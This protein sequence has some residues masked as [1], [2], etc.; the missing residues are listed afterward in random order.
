MLPVWHEPTHNRN[1]IPYAS[2]LTHNALLITPHGGLIMKKTQFCVVT[3]IL[4]LIS[5]IASAQVTFTDVTET[6]GLLGSEIAKSRST[7]WGD[8]DS[9]GDPDLVLM[10]GEIRL[11]RNE[12]N[13][14]FLN[15]TQAVGIPGTRFGSVAGTFA[16]FDN[17][18]D[19]DLLLNTD[20]GD[21]LYRNDGTGAFLD[22]SQAAGIQTRV[23]PSGAYA[24]VFFDYDM[25]GLLDI[26]VTDYDDNPNF[27]YHNEG[28]G[29]FEEVAAQMGADRPE[30]I[31]ASMGIILGDYDD[32][33]DLDLFIAVDG[34]ADVPPGDSV[35]YRNDGNG[36]FV[37]VVRQAG[38][39][40]RANHNG[41]FWDYD[42]DGDLDLLIQGDLD[43][44]NISPMLGSF[45]YRNNGDGTFTDI[46][47]ETG[48]ESFELGT[49]GASFG[50][51]DNDGWL[52]LVIPYEDL[53]TFLYHNNGDGTFTDVGGETGLGGANAGASNFVDYDSDGDLDIFIG[54]GENNTLA[55]RFAADPT[56]YLS[57]GCTNHWLQLRLIGRQSN[58]DSIGARVK[59]T[60]GGLSM[61]Q[62][63][64]GGSGRTISQQDRLPLHFGLGR[65]IQA[66]VVEIRWPSGITQTLTNIPSNQRLT[67]D[68]LDGTMIVIQRASPAVG[69][70]RG[71]TPIQV[72]GEHFLPGSRIFF[73]GVEASDV[74][75][76]SPSLMTAFTPPG[77]RGYVD[78]EV[79]HPDGKRGV[80]RDAFRYTTLRLSNITP[81]SGPVAGGSA[82]QVEGFGIQLGAQVRIGG[83]LLRDVSVTPPVL[84]RGTTPPGVSGTADVSVTNTDGEWDLLY[85]AFTYVPPPEIEEVSPTFAP[86]KG[87][88]DIQISGSGFHQG[89]TVQISGVTAQR[90]HF[91]SP[92]ELNVRTP[93]VSD[94]G[95]Q[96]VVIINPDGQRAILPD[97]VT[98]L[99]PIE[100]KSVE[101]A[102]GGLEGGTRITIVGEP[103]VEIQPQDTRVPARSFPSRFVERVKVFIGDA[104]ATRETVQSDNIITAITPPNTPG[105]K[106]VTVINVDGQE[107]TLRDGFVYNPLPQIARV[108][109]DNGRLAGGTEITVQGSGFLPGARV[110]FST[111]TGTLKAMSS[112]QVVSSTTITAVTT[113]DKSGARDV[114]VRN[115]DKQE[116]ILPEGFTYNPLPTII[117]ITP[118]YGVSSGGTKMIIE[119]NGFLQ[120]A[121]AM[122]GE[123]S[124]TAQWQD[125]TTIEAVAPANPQGAWDVRV[126][127]PDTQEAV[128]REGFISV[129]E[130]AYNYPNPF[131]ASEG[132]TFRY[133][134]DKPVE[135]VAVRIF[136]MA[137]VPIDFVQQI[138][139]NEVKWHNSEVH[140]GLYIYLMEVQLEDRNVRQFRNMLEVYQ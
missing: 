88:R 36:V 127:N 109:P 60:A 75:I 100:I 135:S 37:D 76:A 89:L 125:E 65:N 84:T 86:L 107:D 136:N 101:P 9:D 58:R 120:G 77:Q 97:A 38:I 95:P 35:F 133:V 61:L 54:A 128:K 34:W 69:E 1:R 48:I 31:G 117:S 39:L 118:S 56:L 27:L 28:N 50:D 111:D 87:G 114:V 29:H 4:F 15:V 134:T 71:G 18:G 41:F 32:D 102:S 138:E 68:E 53:R 63:I 21:S 3:F 10:N 104:E 130:L 59:V 67:I 44:I 132:T 119:G 112:S 2:L 129:G 106:D 43:P 42:N 92:E 110:L 47:Q 124:A 20:R 26:Y 113:A 139:S 45:L 91:L 23:S 33:V 90:V 80:L 57:D 17:D 98:I 64:A 11:Y 121:R 115:P 108:T 122:I 14:T 99:A 73:G 126:I 70:P 52:D 5:A 93:E 105:P 103:T 74:Y 25:D 123:R 62:E 83:E 22:V 55:A 49:W 40:H 24:A 94:I 85:R 82:I 96:D 72:Q 19:L 6:A 116:A 66:D 13:G 81:N 137:G 7:T 30:S 8:Y 78:V 140:A 131:S 51:Y 16:D 46:T 79:V 12:G